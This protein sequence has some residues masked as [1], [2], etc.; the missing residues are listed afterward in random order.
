[1][2]RAAADLSHRSGQYAVEGEALHHL[3]RLGDRTVAG[4]LDGLRNRI[5]GPLADLYASHAAAVSNS[6]GV[7][8]DAVSV[9]FEDAGFLLSAADSAAQ[10]AGVHDRTGD[11]RRNSEA[12]ARALRL[13]AACGGVLTPAVRAA[14][15]P[16]PVTSREREIAAMVAA[17]LTNREIAE[18][19]VVSVRTVEGHIYRACI[20][21]DVTDREE[22]GKI[23]RPE[24]N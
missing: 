12:A 13:A 22:L 23:V 21:L 2:A 7:A 11:R 24:N 10:A 9:A 18:R 4:R 14:A 6:D 17:G 15:A 20:K 16:L 8:L 1:L 19:L 3:A 5:A